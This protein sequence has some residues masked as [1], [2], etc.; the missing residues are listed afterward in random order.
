M[1]IRILQIWSVIKEQEY[2]E[3]RE[4]P[5]KKKKGEEHNVATLFL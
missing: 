2:S 3:G 5:V 1:Q 4:I